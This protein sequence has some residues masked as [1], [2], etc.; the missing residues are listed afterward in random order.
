MPRAPTTLDPFAAIAEPKRRRVLEVLADG[1]RPVNDLVET[2]GWSQPQVSKHLGVL[3]KVRLVSVRRL[4]RQR[5]YQVNGQQLKSVHDWVKN[6][7]PFWSH[8]L[9][10]I[11]ER[12]E[13]KVRERSAE[14]KQNP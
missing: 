10:R 12:A 3:K 5:V 2:L 6:F 1:E 14:T 13:R 11:K 7:E 8:Q 4:G 9:R